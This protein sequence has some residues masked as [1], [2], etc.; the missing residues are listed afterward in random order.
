M[1][2]N[3]FEEMF[4]KA[5][6]VEGKRLDH[7]EMIRSA[8]ILATA[9]AYFVLLGMGVYMLSDPSQS[10][11][12]LNDQTRAFIV[13]GVLVIYYSSFSVLLGLL[14]AV[15]DVHIPNL[16]AITLGQN[17]F[18]GI[19]AY[20]IIIIA[21]PV[22]AFQ[23]GAAPPTFPLGALS[24]D[25]AKAALSFG[26]VLSGTSLWA[27][28]Q[29]LQVYAN[30][31]LYY[32]QAEG[33]FRPHIWVLMWFAAAVFLGGAS[34]FIFGIIV[35]VNEG[36]KS[37]VATP[38]NFPPNAVAHSSMTIISGLIMLCYS[39]TLYS[40]S[41]DS[42]ARSTAY[43]FAIVTYLWFILVH[44]MTQYGLYGASVAGEA[45]VVTAGVSV[46]TFAPVI[47]IEDYW[48]EPMQEE[49]L[50]E[51]TTFGQRKVEQIEQVEEMEEQTKVQE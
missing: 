23:N 32:V 21:Q 51:L 47:A 38:Y 37:L 34:M 11:S 31:K 15:F 2:E 8:G 5:M 44:V 35:D 49:G 19:V 28:I 39:A 10:P 14:S 40:A 42:E 9:S 7:V 29:G 30:A 13:A 24:I 25:E 36:N 1:S 22:I 20:C 4:P 6:P 27:C 41:F 43:G 12:Q 50:Q 45:I 16:T 33:S 17:F 46:M 48:R 26:S 3:V 18:L